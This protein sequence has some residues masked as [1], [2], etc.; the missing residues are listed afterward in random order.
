[1]RGVKRRRPAS[2]ARHAGPRTD[3]ALV[4][5]AQPQEPDLLEQQEEWTAEDLRE[6]RR[7]AAQDRDDD[8]DGRPAREFPATADPC[9]EEDSAGLPGRRQ[10]VPLREQRPY[11]PPENLDTLA[12]VRDAL[13]VPPAP[14][15]DDA[16]VPIY[17]R[18][19][20]Q[21]GQR[22]AQLPGKAQL[23]VRTRRVI[24]A[25]ARLENLRYPSP[26]GFSDTAGYRELALQVARLT[27]TSVPLP[28]VLSRPRRAV[29]AT[30]G[31]HAGVRETAPPQPTFTPNPPGRHEPAAAPQ[32]PDGWWDE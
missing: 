6:I 27:G 9:C 21:I 23:P 11:V 31:R 24:T 28:A 5:D 25:Q 30:G 17:D 32:R 7:L 19:A 1:M 4:A 20:R 2:P 22:H 29:E 15:P 16:R 26:D 18:L 14:V 3:T 13:T 8:G 10:R 12:R